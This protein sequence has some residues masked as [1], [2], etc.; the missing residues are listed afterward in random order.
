MIVASNLRM[1]ILGLKMTGK[2]RNGPLLNACPMLFRI[3]SISM[4]TKLL[5]ILSRI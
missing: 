1:V 4:S 3:V 5:D 2:N